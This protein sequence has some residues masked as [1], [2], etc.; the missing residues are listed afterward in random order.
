[1]IICDNV[2]AIRNIRCISDNSLQF[3]VA[4]WEPR[5]SFVCR[6]NRE[7]RMVESQTYRTRTPKMVLETVSATMIVG[8]GF[9]MSI[10][11][12]RHEKAWHS[13]FFESPH[14]SKLWQVLWNL[15]NFDV[16]TWCVLMKSTKTEKRHVMMCKF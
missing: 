7:Y 14:E 1:M 16:I 4:N 3:A 13:P 6:S 11:F 15:M 8:V 9:S 2:V 12:S 5:S 10:K